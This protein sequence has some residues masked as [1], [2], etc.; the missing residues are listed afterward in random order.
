M[1]S[2][3]IR[4]IFSP[5]NLTCCLSKYY[6]YN[7]RLASLKNQTK[8]L[9][10]LSLFQSAQKLGHIYDFFFKRKRFVCTIDAWLPQKRWF[11][12]KMSSFV[13][14]RCIFNVLAGASLNER[15]PRCWN[16]HNRHEHYPTLWIAQLQLWYLSGTSSN[17]K[18]K[19]TP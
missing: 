15:C 19:I 11:D 9:D 3:I 4:K 12:A 14:V 18:N 13:L 17:I 7:E 8:K 16:T 6:F 1:H 2:T 5:L 10:T